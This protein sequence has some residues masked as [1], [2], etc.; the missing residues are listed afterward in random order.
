M[1]GGAVAVDVD[2]VFGCVQNALGGAVVLLQQ[3][4]LT[5]R[6]VF[7]KAQ[8]IAVIGAAPAVNGLVFIA[9]HKYVAVKRR[10][11]DQQLILG[12]VGILELVYQ[13]VFEAVGVFVANFGV[14]AQQARSPEQQIVK[15]DGVVEVQQLF[16]AGIHAGND[17]I[18]VG[19]GGDVAGGEQIV[20]G[21]RDRGVDAGRA[22]DLF[23]DVHLAHGALDESVLVRFIKDNE[24]GIERQRTGLAA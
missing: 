12:Q 21:R 2:H 13:H 4:L 20:L 23:V 8:H 16:I 17:L 6:E 15:I 19:I 22:M 7:F 1:L 3:D 24:I 9:H 18:A 10:Q 11:V 14:F 5:F